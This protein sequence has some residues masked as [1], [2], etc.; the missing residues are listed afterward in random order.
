MTLQR[1]IYDAINDELGRMGADLVRSGYYPEIMGNFIISF[2]L[3]GRDMSLVNE[4]LELLL[5][6]E[7]GGMGNRRILQRDLRQQTAADVQKIVRAALGR[8]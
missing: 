8:R 2:R 4:R 1:E 6:D 3:D 7:L 5:C